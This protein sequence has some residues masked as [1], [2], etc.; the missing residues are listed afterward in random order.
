MPSAHLAP[1]N[2]CV[3]KYLCVGYHG[4]DGSFALLGSQVCRDAV[5]LLAQFREQLNT[6]ISRF[7]SDRACDFAL[8]LQLV[9]RLLKLGVN[10]K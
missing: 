4:R 7:V 1:Y 2:Q 10:F 6:S 5:D 8:L 3:Q 9:E